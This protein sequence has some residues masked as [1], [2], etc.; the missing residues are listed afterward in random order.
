MTLDQTPAIRA[1]MRQPKSARDAAMSGWARNWEFWLAVGLATFLRLWHIELTQFLKDQV[2]LTMLARQAVVHGALPITSNYSSIGTYHPPMA[3]YFLAP[4]FAF[5]TNPLP[6]VISIALVNV[7]AVALT[8]IFA[9]RYFGRP[10]AGAAALLFAT[11]DT[12]INYSRF[13]WQPNYI[14]FVTLLMVMALYRGCVRCKPNALVL[15]ALLLLVDVL[16]HF[17]NLLLAPILLL[18]LLAAPTRPGRR[19]WVI[20]GGIA[21]VMLIPSIVFEGVVSH[22]ADLRQILH[23]SRGARLDL[24]VVGALIGFLDGFGSPQTNGIYEAFRRSYPVLDAVAVLL[25]TVGIL[26]LTV[27][28]GLPLVRGWRARSSAAIPAERQLIS[29]ILTLWRDVTADPEWRKRALLWTWIAVPIAVLL[30]H[31]EPVTVHYLLLLAPGV[32]IVQGLGMCAILDGLRSLTLPSAL[33]TSRAPSH[34]VRRGG[35]AVVLVLVALL[36]AGDGVRWTLYPASLAS[37][38][39][40][41]YDFYG[42]PLAEV[43]TA[44]ARLSA[45]QREQ[46]ASAA[47]IVTPVHGRY[48]ETYDYIFANERPNRTTFDLHC[49]VLPAP[50]DGP[51]LI[52]TTQPDT[53]PANLL[54]SLPS[55]THIA[56]IPMVGGAPFAVYRVEGITPPLAGEHATPQ[57]TFSDGAGHGLQLQGAALVQP[58]LVRLRW[59]VLDQPESSREPRYRVGVHVGSTQP[60]FPGADARTDCVPTHLH[61]GQTL[62]T[63]LALSQNVAQLPAGAPVSVSVQRNTAGVDMPTVGPLR[64]VTGRPSDSPLV[65][66]SQSSDPSGTPTAAPYTLPPGLLGAGG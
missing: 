2:D 26:T 28:I 20:G 47:Y 64:F 45:L 66:L 49:L 11:S 14:A 30:R 51:V 46:H 41:A 33:G 53:D 56:D 3:I 10:A 62:I 1:P 65:T 31:S 57:V 21:F 54:S 13:I 60:G 24:Q 37:G 58:N 5:T 59:T 36:V 9:L 55:A 42:F 27:Q 35:V 38:N 34:L 61:A 39:F 8:Y 40:V 15:G 6:G 52:V 23:S 29:Q 7:L 19:S 48:A 43:Q 44:D 32:F 50:Q 4:F 25:F 63:W 16:I 22:G 17:A 18:A 12:L